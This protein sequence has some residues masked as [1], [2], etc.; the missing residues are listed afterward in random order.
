VGKHAHKTMS[1]EEVAAIGQTI[2]KHL[3]G[4]PLDAAAEEA[5]LVAAARKRNLKPLAVLV[6][7]NRVLKQ[8][9]KRL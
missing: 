4:E 5:A 6:E 7:R 8:S 1:P 2:Q 9:R 3:D